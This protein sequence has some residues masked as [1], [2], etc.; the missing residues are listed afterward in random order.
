MP[1]FSDIAAHSPHWQKFGVSFIDTS[2]IVGGGMPAFFASAS[3]FAMLARS[4]ERNKSNTPGLERQSCIPR[5]P[6]RTPSR[7][8]KYSGWS[9]PYFSHGTYM[10][11]LWQWFGGP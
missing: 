7:S 5:P 3:P 11:A 1:I 9:L 8:A 6:T 2:Y 10:D 4:F